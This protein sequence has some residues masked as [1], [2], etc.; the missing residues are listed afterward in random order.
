MPS[1]RARQARIC[2]CDRVSP[3][4]RECCS[5]LFFSKRATSCSRKPSVGGFTS[6]NVNFQKHACRRPVRLQSKAVTNSG[7]VAVNQTILYRL[8]KSTR[9]RKRNVGAEKDGADVVD[10]LRTS[11]RS[12]FLGA[13]VAARQSKEIVCDSGLCLG[14]VQGPP[15]TLP[16]AAAAQLVDLYRQDRRDRFDG[17][18]RCENWRDK[19]HAAAHHP[20]WFI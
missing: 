12:G 6:I 20:S 5:N 13:S 8:Y 7:R 3:D 2:H 15:Y 1:F 18:W 14:Q 19:A 9:M 16:P 11:S 4:P 10:Q 17:R